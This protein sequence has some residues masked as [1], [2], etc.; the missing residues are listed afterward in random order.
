MQGKSGVKLTEKQV[1]DIYLSDVVDRTIGKLVATH[2]GY[3]PR[4]TCLSGKLAKEYGISAKSVRDIWNHRTWSSVTVPY[5]NKIHGHVRELATG[6]VFHEVSVGGVGGVDDAGGV[7]GVGG[8]SDEKR[9][10]AEM[11]GEDDFDWQASLVP[12]VEMSQ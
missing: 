9:G 6:C 1:L 4:C 3:Q 2:R 11:N 7:S 5:R 12:W 8:V 10:E